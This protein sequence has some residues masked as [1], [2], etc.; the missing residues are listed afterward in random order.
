[1]CQYKDSYFYDFSLKDLSFL[2]L[3]VYSFQEV[4]LSNEKKEEIYDFIKVFPYQI[5]ISSSKIINAYAVLDENVII[6]TQGLLNLPVN[7]IK[8][9]IAH[10]IGHFYVDGKVTNKA[11]F[12]R[13][14]FIAFVL[15][16][17]DILLLQDIFIL[18]IL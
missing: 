10:E 5:K 4:L 16:F 17:V 12:I 15:S 3:D 18:F 6:I 2:Q 1:M 9:A 13:L 7:E 14:F 8:A 11:K